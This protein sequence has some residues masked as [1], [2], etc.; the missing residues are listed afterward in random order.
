MGP[1]LKSLKVFMPVISSRWYKNA[2]EKGLTNDDLEN[3]GRL[4]GE[5]G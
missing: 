4:H 2:V 1:P 3:Q 5:G